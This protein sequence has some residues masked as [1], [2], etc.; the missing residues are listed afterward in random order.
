MQT[1]LDFSQLPEILTQDPAGLTF[2]LGGP[3]T[4]KT[5]LFKKVAQRFAETG[6]KAALVDADV[7][8]STIGPSTTIGVSVIGGSTG[9][10]PK[11]AVGA[12]TDALAA[13][14]SAPQAL[15]FVGSNNPVSR[16]TQ[17][18]VGSRA[19]VD[20]A[21]ELG[22]TSVVFDSSGLVAPP[23][24]HILK[25]HKLELLR[26]R[27]VVALEREDE[28]APLLRL[29][30]SCFETEV[31]RVKPPAEAKATSAA[32][33]AEYRQ[34]QYRR[35]FKGAKTMTLLLDGLALYPPQFLSRHGDLSGLL[36]GLQ[37]KRWETVAIGTIES[38]GESAIKVKSPWPTSEAVCGLLAGYIKLG[39]GWVET[40]H[41]PA[42][43]FL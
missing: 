33:R 19:M 25:Y 8:Q 26:P 24:G 5:T 20:R 34:K 14:I 7:G 43:Y 41:L 3:D 18:L 1:R 23:Y 38:V 39:D 9:D 12:A 22:V 30:T 32:K 42:R 6:I 4:G 31:L 36:V 40:G 37:N 17:V 13:D 27:R 11:K 21:F 16:L 2:L 15:Y 29:I 28:L 35:Y 10:M